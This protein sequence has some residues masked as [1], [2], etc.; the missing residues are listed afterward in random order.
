[1][2]L[3]YLVLLLSATAGMTDQFWK[4]G[5]AEFAARGKVPASF[6]GNQ[7]KRK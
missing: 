4:Q 5:L 2:T 1:M 6:G 7:A 3:A